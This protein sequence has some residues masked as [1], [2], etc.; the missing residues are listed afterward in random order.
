[1]ERK[2]L[3]MTGE[4]LVTSFDNHYG[5][6]EHLHRYALARDMSKDK[7]VLDI[8]CGEG[9]GSHLLAQV[10]KTVIGVDISYEA[11]NHA[12]LKYQSLNLSFLQ[13]AASHI[14]LEDNSIDLVVSFETIEH[15]DE[16]EQMFKEI[17]RVLKKEGV[18][19]LSSPEKSIYNKRDPNNP[20]HVKELSKEELLDIT[21]KNFPYYKVMQ[22]RIVVCSL[23]TQED[24]I[25]QTSFKEYDGS[26]YE[27]TEKFKREVFFNVPFFN[28]IIASKTPYASFNVPLN[29]IFNAYEAYNAENELNKKTI[30]TYQ[31]STSFRLGQFFVKPVSRIV[32]L[33]KK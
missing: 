9:Y 28:I 29:S 19:V 21:S 7:I 26:F 27:I 14:P 24:Q 15:H 17:N 25:E 4:R 13:G 6:F 3:E 22:Q 10:A 32:H 30:Q 11:V 8:A 12:S 16:H 2:E 18:L 5:T 23:I 33:F 20:F 31:E 1:M